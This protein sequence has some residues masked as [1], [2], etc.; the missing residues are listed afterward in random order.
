M[1]HVLFLLIVTAC[2]SGCSV[3]GQKNE[4]HRSFRGLCVDDV[5]GT[6]GLYNPERGFRLEVALDVANKNYLWNPAAFPDIRSF[7]PCASPASRIW[8]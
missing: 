5:N 7:R 8:P 1:K 4:G 3:F 2:L 6:D